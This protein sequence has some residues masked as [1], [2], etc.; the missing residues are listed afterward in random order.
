MGL[1]WRAVLPIENISVILLICS[2]VSSAVSW[3]FIGNFRN[4]PPTH[5]SS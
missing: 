2:V 4:T 1:T 3:S 5:W